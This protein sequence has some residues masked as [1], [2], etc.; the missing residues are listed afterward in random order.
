MLTAPFYVS[1]ARAATGASL[2]AAEAAVTARRASER[3]RGT[4]RADLH[5]CAHERRC[6]AS[7]LRAVRDRRAV[8]AD[9]GDAVRVEVLERV[10]GAG[11]AVDEACGGDVVGAQRGAAAVEVGLEVHGRVA[12]LG[13]GVLALGAVPDADRVPDLVRQHLAQ[14]G[15]VPERAAAEAAVH[16]D[17]PLADAEEALA[18]HLVVLD[19]GAV[20]A[21]REDAAAGG[22]GTHLI[23]RVV[24]DDLREAVAEEGHGGDRLAADE[25][26]GG[27]GA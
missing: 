6:G 24:E 11:G 25:V 15:A 8:V 7:R 19:E 21:E 1:R 5:A 16:G 20:A 23:E 18:V 17:V 14:V 22:A 3:A 10:A 12:Q 2:A 27:A 26:Q 13:G 9:V 4:P